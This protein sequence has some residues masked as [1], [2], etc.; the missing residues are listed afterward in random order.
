MMQANS[1]TSVHTT[2]KSYDE[3]DLSYEEYC[4]PWSQ[5]IF[6][7]MNLETVSASCKNDAASF[8]IYLS[9]Y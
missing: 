9:K 4:N 8:L 1:A 2:S 7:E 5:T 6:E 3:E